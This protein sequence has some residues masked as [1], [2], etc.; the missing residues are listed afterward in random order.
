M[1]VTSQ[2]GQELNVF[3]MGLFV[4][5]GLIQVG[6]APT[7]GNIEIE[8]LGELGRSLAGVGVAPGAER[9]EDIAVG[10]ER[11][12]TMHHGTDADGCEVFDLNAVLFHHVGAQAGVA[13]LQAVPDGFDAVC[14]QAVDQ[15]V[16]PL[17]T[18]LCDGLI[19]F[20][21][22]HGLDTG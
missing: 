3:Y 7:K 2:R 6:D 8:E 19:I 5:D 17:V 15:L 14:P 9:H 20:I 1:D 13:V 12:I 10:A 11:H 4:E 21:D 22:E 18:A 16:L